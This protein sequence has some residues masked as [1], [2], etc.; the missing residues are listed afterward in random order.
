MFFR[1]IVF[2]C[3]GLAIA[4]LAYAP[5]ANACTPLRYVDGVSYADGDFAEQIAARAHTIQI[6][7]VRS[8]HLL[9]RYDT[10][11]ELFWQTGR[12]RTDGT[13]VSR[14]RDIYVFELEAVE[15]LKDGAGDN[16]PIRARALALDD[17]PTLW[18]SLGA[19]V[20]M[21]LDTPSRDGMVIRPVA[22]DPYSATSCSSALALR[23]GD[24]YL[25]LRDE[26]GNILTPTYED[27]EWR[28]VLPISAR[29]EGNGETFDIQA[30]G[31]MEVSPATSE[32][33]ARIRAALQAN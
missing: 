8:R 7:E 18:R 24:R 2:G 6:V 20:R 13:A 27:G 16:V 12:W 9:A 26:R 22:V 25:I 14:S 10:R 32:F 30:P 3:L 17:D 4:G 21:M 33:I 23:E 11:A 31:V 1:G 15:T 28:N 29:N 19:M 5:A